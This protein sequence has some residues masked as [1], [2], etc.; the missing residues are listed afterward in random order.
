M[1]LFLILGISRVTILSSILFSIYI[2]DLLVSN[3]NG[4]PIDNII[5]FFEGQNWNEV[6]T[7]INLGLSII[8]KW[9]IKNSLSINNSNAYFP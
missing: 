5:L 7:K 3:I 8:N 6:E 2:N 1:F 9:Y 4:N